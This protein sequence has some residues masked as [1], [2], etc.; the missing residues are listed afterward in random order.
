MNKAYSPQTNSTILLNVES[1]FSQ[2]KD[3]DSF[4][5][6]VTITN[7]VNDTKMKTLVE[8]LSKSMYCYYSVKI[9]T[10]SSYLVY[11]KLNCKVIYC[12]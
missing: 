2:Q 5:V 6:N 10:Y 9:S 12:V 4:T 8:N 7:E 11:G 1:L 3:I